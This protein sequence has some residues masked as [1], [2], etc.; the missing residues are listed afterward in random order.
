MTFLVEN[1]DESDQFILGRDSVRNVDITIDLNDKLI[2]FKD[3]ERENKKKP[4]NKILVNQ[5][6]V[7]IFLDKKVRL[8]GNQ[9]VVATLRLRNSIELSNNR[10]VCLV[11]NPNS[12]SS[13][14][15]GRISHSLRTDAV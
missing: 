1:L 7:P 9:P 5:T 8:K 4:V 14:I 12:R 15:L 6:K 11:P 10:Q 3:P 13:A 2:K